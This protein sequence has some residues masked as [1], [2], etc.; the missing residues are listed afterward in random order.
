M[1]TV[2]EYGLWE[3]NEQ[4]GR[5]ESTWDQ[6]LVREHVFVVGFDDLF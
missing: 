5:E 2:A 1:N 4:L 6:N 3:E